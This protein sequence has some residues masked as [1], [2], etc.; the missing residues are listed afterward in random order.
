VQDGLDMMLI[1]NKALYALPMKDVEAHFAEHQLDF[2]RVELYSIRSD[3]EEQAKEIAELAREDP[4][5][6][7]NLAMEHS[8]DEKSKSA[9]GYIGS[10][11]RNEVTGVIEAAV[12]GAKPGT[13]IGPVKTDKG[14]NV[15]K[16]GSI[17]KPKVEDHADEIRRELFDALM[18]KRR[19]DAK[20]TVKL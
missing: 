20:I 19:T 14:F 4:N 17:A 1:R 16:V 12:F 8:T 3:S 11:A 6:F 5:A 9:G 13:I 2:E 18:A 15:F 10:V 7:F